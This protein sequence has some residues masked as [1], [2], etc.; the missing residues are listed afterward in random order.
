MSNC[1]TEAIQGG[2]GW[3]LLYVWLIALQVG[4]AAAA[5]LLGALGVPGGFAYEVT[6]LV[7]G[8]LWIVTAVWFAYTAL[9]AGLLIPGLRF[10]LSRATFTRSYRRYGGPDQSDVGGGPGVS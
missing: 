9:W 2:Q 3:L 4:A 1:P 7:T 10:V 8:Y 6:R 5:A